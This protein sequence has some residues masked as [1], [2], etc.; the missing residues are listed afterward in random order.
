MVIQTWRWG[1]ETFILLI[2]FIFKIAGR[3][4][5]QQTNLK[6]WQFDSLDLR[7]YDQR[8]K[9]V[10]KTKDSSSKMPTENKGTP[11]PLTLGSENNGVK[12]DFRQCCKYG[13][14][15][16]QKNPMH[17]QKFRHPKDDE[18]VAQSENK[19]GMECSLYGMSKS[20]W[21]QIWFI[22]PTWL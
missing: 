6:F 3:K 11:Q 12:K 1:N 20:L 16:Y 4:T 7:N 19:D 14:D 13:K 9:K 2:F 21:S 5:K 8:N 18:D 22:F 10:D 17:H 15:C